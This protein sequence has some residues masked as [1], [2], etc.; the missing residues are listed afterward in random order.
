MWTGLTVQIRRHPLI[1]LFGLA[2]GITWLGV[3]PYAMGVWQV[4]MFP[5]GPIVAAIVI[6]A[7]CGGWTETRQLLLRMVQWRVAPRWYAF[8][9]LLPAAVTVAAAYANVIFFGAPDPTIST[10]AALPSVIPF[11]ALMMVNPLQGTLGEELGWRGF[12]LP[13]L[14]SNRSPLAASLLLGA[15]VA[16]WHAPLFATG[17]YAN[18]WLHVS[19]LIAFSIPFTLLFR[20]SGGSVLLAMLLH[21]SMNLSPEIV[22][23]SSFTGADYERSLVLFLAIGIVASIVSAMLGWRWLTGQQPSPRVAPARADTLGDHAPGEARA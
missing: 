21:T 8:A 10:L 12:A 22:L 18:A 4:P 3:I 1:A 14:L 17:M 11:F 5:F 2:Y 6:S 7:V 15:L 19:F 23:Y 20:G 9:L 13:R 16:I